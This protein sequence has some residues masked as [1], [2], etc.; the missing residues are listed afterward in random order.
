MNEKSTPLKHL[1]LTGIVTAI[2]VVLFS[3]LLNH[4]PEFK[5]WVAKL[6]S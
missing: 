6:F 2:T 4:W 5:H 3:R 1:I